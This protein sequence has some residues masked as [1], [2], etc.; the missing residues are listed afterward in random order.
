[1]TDTATT[2]EAGNVLSDIRIER[3][4]QDTKWGPQ[5]HPDIDPTSVGAAF[6]GSR[7]RTTRHYD[8]PTAHQTQER[9]SERARTGQL[10]WTDILLEEVAEAVEATA[11]STGALR[12]ELVQVAA[13]AAAWIEAIDRRDT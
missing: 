4:R 6:A 10:S 13:V 7:G 1:M 2:S 8:I 11:Q 5:N 9:C 3:A 12:E